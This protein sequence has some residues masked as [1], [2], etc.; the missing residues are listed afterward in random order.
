MIS[1]AILGSSFLV[2]SLRLALR[3][4][5]MSP[6]NPIISRYLSWTRCSLC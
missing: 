4:V 6:G 2:L 5:S 3:E 1:L